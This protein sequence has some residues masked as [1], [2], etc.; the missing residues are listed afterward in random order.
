[1]VP[2]FGKNGS[3]LHLPNSSGGGG[4][5]LWWTTAAP[6]RSGSST[7]F[8][9]FIYFFIIFTLRQSKPSRHKHA[10]A[11]SLSLSLDVSTEQATL[12]GGDQRTLHDLN[13]ARIPA[14]N[15]KLK[16]EFD[17]LEVAAAARTRLLTILSGNLQK[18]REVRLDLARVVRWAFVLGCF[19]FFWC[20]LT[21]TTPCF[22]AV[23]VVRCGAFL[24]FMCDL[25]AR[26]LMGAGG[27][28]KGAI[29]VVSFGLWSA[30]RCETEECDV[31]VTVSRCGLLCGRWVFHA[32]GPLVRFT[33]SQA[34]GHSHAKAPREGRVENNPSQD[35]T[36]I[37]SFPPSCRCYR[38]VLVLRGV[39]ES[40]RC[41]SCWTRTGEG[42]GAARGRGRRRRGWRRLRSGG[43]SCQR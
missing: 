19:F 5:R 24:F 3:A 6:R 30:R 21:C 42:S 1:M 31:A 17:A 38:G 26:A 29:P 39:Y 34:R 25:W 16:T 2:C 8:F 11:L 12:T 7:F 15:A 32:S 13:T 41:D 14:L 23:R 9:I 10:R 36:S 40:R 35:T 22:P 37:P 33:I 28:H 4:A 18:R 20:V 27:E 43:R